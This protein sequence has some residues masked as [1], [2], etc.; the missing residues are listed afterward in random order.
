MV[1]VTLRAQ[2][3]AAPLNIATYDGGNRLTHPSVVDAGAGGWNGFRYWMAATPFPGSLIE[4]PSI[5]QSSDGSTWTV[6]AGLTNPVVAYP[7]ASYFNSDTHIILHSGTMYLYYREVG[8]DNN[9][10]R[11]YVRSS[12]DGVTWAA[13][14]EVL[15][16]DKT[17]QRALS[18]A[19]VRESDGSYSMWAVDSRPAKNVLRRYTAAGPTST[20]SA[21]DECQL[22]PPEGKYLWHVDVQ[23]HAGAYWML[24]HILDGDDEA[25]NGGEIYVATSLDGRTWKRDRFPLLGKRHVGVWDFRCY[26]SCWQPDGSGGWNIWYAGHDSVNSVGPDWEIGYT[27]IASYPGR[28]GGGVAP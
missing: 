14:V 27:S 26:R 6:P 20:F 9:D 23:R 11:V 22:P 19:V 1:A 28:V 5:W 21:A 2:Q 12:T 25:W 15:L 7:G 3:T 16:L 24:A 4:N 13:A 10:E 17:V 18:P 8:V